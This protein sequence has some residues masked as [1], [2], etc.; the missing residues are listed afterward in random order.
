M[1]EYCEE[2]LDS[3]K[4]VVEDIPRNDFKL[5]H[6]NTVIFTVDAAVYYNQGIVLLRRSNEPAK[7]TFWT[8]GGR[9]K[10]GVPIVESVREKV[11]VECGLGLSGL[12]LKIGEGRMFFKNDPFGHGKGTDTYGLIYLGIGKGRISLD[13]AHDDYKAVGPTEYSENFRRELHPFIRDHLDI[14]MEFIESANRSNIPF[15]RYFNEL[16]IPQS[17]EQDILK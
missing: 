1:N 10:K 3:K 12:L 13:G 15:E 17:R 16:L 11:A 14:V 4:I 6:E 7:G 9:V 5:I 8:P 2:N